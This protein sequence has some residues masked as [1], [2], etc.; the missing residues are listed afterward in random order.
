MAPPTVLLLGNVNPSDPEVDGNAVTMFEIPDGV[1]LSEAIV[2]ISRTYDG[3]HSEDPPEWV[4]SDNA[5][6]AAAVAAHYTY[7]DGQRFRPLPDDSAEDAEAEALPA[8]TCQVGRP[9][10]WV[11]IEQSELGED[12]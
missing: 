8:H 2:T 9:S 10:D 1:G 4:E 12:E 3:Y 11:G 6:L 7:G 5:V